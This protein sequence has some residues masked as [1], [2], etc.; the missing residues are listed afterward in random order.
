MNVFLYDLH[1]GM[2]QIILILL[3]IALVYFCCMQFSEG[4]STPYGPYQIGNNAYQN[5][6]GNAPAGVNAVAGQPQYEQNAGVPSVNPV[7]P[8]NPQNVWAEYKRQP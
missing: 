8:G 6:L 5:G 2:K 4:F 3:G 1:T 7:P